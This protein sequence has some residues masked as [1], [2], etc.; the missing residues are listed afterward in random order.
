M[1]DAE[2]SLFLHVICTV[3]PTS[4]WQMRHGCTMALASVLRHASRNVCGSQAL[5]TLVLGYLKTR[6]KDDK[7][8]SGVLFFIYFYVWVS[9]V[10]VL[11]D[12]FY[13]SSTVF[14][15]YFMDV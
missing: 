13:S 3:A 4:T 14:G 10:H 11:T 6:A 1:G 5:L 8:R 7:V 9:L 2:F 15:I 12:H